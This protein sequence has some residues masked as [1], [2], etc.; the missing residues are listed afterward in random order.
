MENT[1]KIIKALKHLVKSN[2]ELSFGIDNYD[3][4]KWER[5]LSWIEKQE[6][7]TKFINSIQIGDK[8]TRN[9]DGVLVNL[10]QLGRKAKP[11]EMAA[12]DMAKWK[13]NHK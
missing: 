12:I 4:V 10:S 6:A 13:D 3:G 11:C 9:Q 8:I 2:K 1:G 5:I 7:H